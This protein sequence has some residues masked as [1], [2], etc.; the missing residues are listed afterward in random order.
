MSETT[1]E[2]SGAERSGLASVFR[3]SLLVT[4]TA[5][6]VIGLMVAFE[7][8]GTES[9]LVAALVAT[10]GSDYFVIAIVGLAAGWLAV[11]VALW[12]RL[13]GVDEAAPP[14]VEGV[15]SAP[16][17]G[18]SFER[19]SRSIVAGS[20]SPMRDRLREAAVQSLVRTR[21][22]SRDAAE[23]R[24]DDGTWTDDPIAAAFLS[25]DVD[26]LTQIKR[27]ATGGGTFRRAVE[28]TVD[29]IASI[30]AGEN[31]RD[32]TADRDPGDV[33]ER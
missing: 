32:R 26:V 27:L 1:A 7:P 2:Q 9:I 5:V 20:A 33:G 6:F 31:S 19:S 17:P 10:L 28:R 24:I 15:E 13:S 16:Y 30:E 21:H 29:A 22:D 11:V 23:R 25:G 18:A 14:V 4:G 8:D 12:R 3:R